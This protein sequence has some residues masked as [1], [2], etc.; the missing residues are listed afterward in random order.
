MDFGSTVEAFGKGVDGAGV[1]VIVLG[2]IGATALFLWRRPGSDG[3]AAYRLYRQRLG[4]VIL[5]GL[6][7]LLAGDIVRT[8]AIEP[9]FRSV[10]ILAVIVL[11]RSFLS[12]ELEMEIEG[13]W[14]WQH[15]T[16]PPPAAPGDAG[17]GP[18]GRTSG[19]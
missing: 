7:F 6:E 12:T 4:R 9:T 2:A 3:L 17:A 18:L 5:L 16:E 15:R 13:R 1:A 14:P 19:S 8:V 11:I 10:G